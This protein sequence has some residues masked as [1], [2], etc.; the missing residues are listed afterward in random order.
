M[1]RIVVASVE[2]SSSS[3]FS[4]SLIFT[5]V[6]GNENIYYN[7]ELIFLLHFLEFP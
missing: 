5:S 2:N 3:T 1:N 6:R 4:N 7:L